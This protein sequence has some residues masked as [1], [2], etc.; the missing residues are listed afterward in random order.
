MRLSNGWMDPLRDRSRFL[1][2]QPRTSRFPIFEWCQWIIHVVASQQSGNAFML[3][4]CM[5]RSKCTKFMDPIGWL[6]KTSR[7]QR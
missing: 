2:A 5:T 7:P 6:G 1:L 4:L 3:R